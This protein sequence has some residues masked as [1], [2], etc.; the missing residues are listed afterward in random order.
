VT[1]YQIKQPSHILTLVGN[2]DARDNIAETNGPPRLHIGQG[3]AGFATAAAT[4]VA[5]GISLVVAAVVAVCVSD[6]RAANAQASQVAVEAALN[7]GQL[8]AEAALLAAPMAARYAWSIDAP[9]G[10]LRIWAEPEASKLSIAGAAALDGPALALFGVTDMA[11]LKARLEAL[12]SADASE[13]LQLA[14]LDSAPAWRQCARSAISPYGGARTFAIP[15]PT[16]PA[17]GPFNT[18]AGEVWRILV[19]SA[20]GWTDERLVRFTGDRYDPW[21]VIERRFY[22][23]GRGVDQCETVLGAG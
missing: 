4:I 19:T 23:G 8:R 6:L 3:D 15:K 7:G 22:R 5:L 10:S 20:D 1:V 11:S 18:R 17:A 12:A 9:A 2:H 21:G 13:G 14:A 16:R